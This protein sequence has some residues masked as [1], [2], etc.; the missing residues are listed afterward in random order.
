MIFQ[1]VG[2][3]SVECK[4]E[5][6]IKVFLKSIGVLQEFIRTIFNYSR[7]RASSLQYSR[8]LE[9]QIEKWAS[10]LGCPPPSVIST[11]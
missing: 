8:V 6:Q 1:F 5:F 11:I 7:P 10:E 4:I 9:E 2:S 3:H